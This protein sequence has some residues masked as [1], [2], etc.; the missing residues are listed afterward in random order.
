MVNNLGN[1]TVPTQAVPGQ[2]PAAHPEKSP[3]SKMSKEQLIAVYN[4]FNDLSDKEKRSPDEE[5]KLAQ[6]SEIISNNLT[7]I[8]RYMHLSLG[9]MDELEENMDE[10]EAA[11][12]AIPS[13]EQNK[14]VRRMNDL[15]DKLE[16]ANPKDQPK[17]QAEIDKITKFLVEGEISQSIETSTTISTKLKRIFWICLSLTS[18]RPSEP[19]KQ[20]SFC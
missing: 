8:K 19:R 5:K 16:T 9:D 14:M 15:Y 17:I 13:Y 12:I 20:H 18:I 4:E 1:E 11:I 10:A 2:A 6:L 3:A 7:D